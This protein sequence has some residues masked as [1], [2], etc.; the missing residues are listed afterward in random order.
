MYKMLCHF[1]VFRIMFFLLCCQP[2]Q[3]MVMGKRLSKV[4]AGSV[5][6]PNVNRL[7]TFISSLDGLW[8]DSMNNMYYTDAASCVIRR[9]L[10]LTP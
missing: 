9:V 3:T 10:S 8:G 4:L 1:N 2:F 5:V 7:A 6:G